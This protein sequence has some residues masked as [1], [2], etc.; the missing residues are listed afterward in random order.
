[1]FER[2]RARPRENLSKYS[3]SPNRDYNPET[4]N[5]EAGVLNIIYDE[6]ETLEYTFIPQHKDGT[7]HCIGR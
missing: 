2:S 1:M 4:S 5:F 3:R 7:A 6:S